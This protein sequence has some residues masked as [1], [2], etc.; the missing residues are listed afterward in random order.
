M[1]LDVPGLVLLLE[2]IHANEGTLDRQSLARV[3]RGFSGSHFPTG[4]QE[5]FNLLSGVVNGL[6]AVH[7]LQENKAGK[8]TLNEKSARTIAGFLLPKLS[9]ELTRV[10]AGN[11]LARARAL[12]RQQNPE[13]LIR[14]ID[15][16][17]QE[18]NPSTAVDLLQGIFKQVNKMVDLHLLKAA[19][20]LGQAYDFVS[21]C[22]SDRDSL[23]RARACQ[24]LGQMGNK[25]GV[26]SLLPLLQDP[27][28]GV[29][30]QVAET[31]GELGAAEVV[32]DL[33]M[34]SR[35]YSE[36]LTVREKA[37]EALRRI[38]NR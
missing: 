17:V 32:K 31:L 26:A 13:V 22:L 2:V 3:L 23:V 30:A 24:A 29:R 18:V 27:V 7:W 33:E 11:D 38:K 21:N 25:V 6:I 10:L 1:P 12:L 37:A 16:V 36:S 5:R 15:W 19:G 9:R 14:L 8:L 20:Q 28:V 4:D 34:I 35:D